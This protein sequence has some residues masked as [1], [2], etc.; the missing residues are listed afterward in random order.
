[1]NM[2]EAIEKIIKATNL[3]EMKIRCMIAAEI[4][5]LCGLID[6]EVAL[7][8]IMKRYSINFEE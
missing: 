4:N 7:K 5:G 1:M 3:T 8:L 6:E 2:N